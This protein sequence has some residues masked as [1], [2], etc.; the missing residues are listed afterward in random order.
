MAD[1]LGAAPYRSERQDDLLL[2][3]R[4]LT[5]DRAIYW[6]DVNDEKQRVRIL[7]VFF[8]GQN[9]VRHMLTRLLTP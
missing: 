2:G 1:R 7:A 5:I 9:H 8:G 3:L 4:P 6:S